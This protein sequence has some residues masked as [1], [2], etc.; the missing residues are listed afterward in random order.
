MK[1]KNILCIFLIV[2]LLISSNA[3]ALGE[4][5]VFRG[6]KMYT[7]TVWLLNDEDNTVIFQNVKTK[8]AYGVD[9]LVPDLEYKAVSVIPSNIFTKDGRR[10]S[11]EEV[12][13]NLL[14]SKVVF[15][16]GVNAYEHKVLYLEIQ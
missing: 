6:I 3:F 13:S 11:F 9:I 5:R 4:D 16:S 10:V 12:N 15:I 8:N 1:I 7:G 14:D 2:V